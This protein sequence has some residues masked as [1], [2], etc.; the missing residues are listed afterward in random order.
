VVGESP[1][2][3][4]IAIGGRLNVLGFRQKP[5]VVGG[6]YRWWRRVQGV[7]VVHRGKTGMAVTPPHVST[8]QHGHNTAKKLGIY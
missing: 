6:E 5:R 1:K 3:Q 7:Q 4:G 2:W 8:L